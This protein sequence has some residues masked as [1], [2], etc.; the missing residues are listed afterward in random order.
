MGE[1]LIALPDAITYSF[2]PHTR[3]SKQLIEL[4]QS[5]NKEIMLHLPMQP[6]GN[7]AMGPGGLNETMSRHQF[8]KTVRQD[9]NAIPGAIGIN[10]HMGSLLTQNPKSMHWLMEELKL[11]HK[12]YFVDSR[13]HASSVAA[14]L[15][16]DYRIPVASRDIFLDHSISKADIDFQF[17]RLLRR[18][19]RVGNALAIGHPYTETFQALKVWLPKFVEQ[20]IEIVSV[21]RYISLVE[22]RRVLW[23]AS[24]SRSHKVVKN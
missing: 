3:Y 5:R 13:T 9:I 20:G 8:I 4:A 22:S 2:L 14:S 15:A 16:K 24:L 19:N 1:S 21:S 10:N 7:K 11:K 12:L 17:D 6:L 23:Q 18:A